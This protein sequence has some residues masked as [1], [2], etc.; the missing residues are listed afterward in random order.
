[1]RLLLRPPGR[2]RKAKVCELEHIVRADE[3]RSIFLS[4]EV[5]A[6]VVDNTVHALLAVNVTQNVYNKRTL[7]NC[8]GWVSPDEVGT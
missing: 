4:V 7:T 3:T 1:M 2:W 6:N 8:V 5:T